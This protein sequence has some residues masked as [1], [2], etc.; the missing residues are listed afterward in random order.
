MTTSARS[1]ALAAAAWA[2]GSG[3]VALAWTAAG[4]GFPFGTGDPHNASSPLRAVDPA[5]GAPLSAAVLLLAAAAALVLAARAAPG[6]GVLPAAL[7]YAWAVAAALLVVVPDARLLTLAGY[8]PVL[9]VGAPFGYPPVDYGEIFTGAAAAQVAGV[10]GGV[11]LARAALLRGRAAA[12][13]CVACGR[14][15]PERGWTT[16]AAAARWGR[17]A[18]AVAAVIPALYAVTRLA[19]AAGVPLGIPAEFL[20]EMRASGLVWAGAG[21]GAFALAGAVLT[22]GLTQRWGEVFPRWLPGLAG[23]RVPVRLATVPAGLVAVLVTSA[24]VG[25]LSTDGFLGMVGGGISAASAP[26][27]L[28]PV[29]GVALGAAALAYHL[30]RRGGCATC[31][32]GVVRAQVAGAR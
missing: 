11:L 29:W 24:S 22:L 2:G 26:M 16:P 3:A 10:A 14:R 25:L 32:A 31:G 9:V 13:A 5:V 6:R 30:R 1:A 27:L 28:W 21:L 12:G 18:V 15:H 7:G 4:R 23:R 8:L 19:W 17:W 20:R